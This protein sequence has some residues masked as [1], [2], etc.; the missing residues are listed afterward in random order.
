MKPGP[1][2]PPVSEKMR[3]AILMV[4][5]P[6]QD[7]ING[8]AQQLKIVASG[9]PKAISR[10]MTPS[11]GNRSEILGA[12]SILTSR[13]SDAILQKSM[14]PATRHPLITNTHSMTRPACVNR[15]ATAESSVENIEELLPQELVKEESQQILTQ[16]ENSL[17]PG[18]KCMTNSDLQNVLEGNKVVD[19]N[20]IVDLTM[21]AS[22]SHNESASEVPLPKLTAITA[23]TNNKPAEENGKKSSR[24]ETG[25]NSMQKANG[26]STSGP[27]KRKKKSKNLLSSKTTRN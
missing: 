1:S 14:R 9:Q 17:P 13:S 10:A 12:A 24:K 8:Q 20:Q 16:A 7:P 23:S 5:T 18:A 27:E 6:R 4:K 25:S 3:K 11:S 21:K 22:P 26:S 15:E 2:R 19:P